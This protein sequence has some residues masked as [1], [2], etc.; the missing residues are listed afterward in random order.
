MEKTLT[1]A[2]PT[3]NR[4]KY[5]KRALQSISEQYDD[6]LEII[7][8]DNASQDETEE[9]VNEMRKCIPIKYIK[10]EEN[11]GYDMNFLQCFRAASGKYTVLLGDD[12]VIID[13]KMNVIL[14]FL[15]SNDDLSL[16]FLNH[17][18]FIGDYDKT[19]PGRLSFD[20]IPNKSGLSKTEFFDY[21][22]GEIIFISSV[23][24]STKRV[25]KVKNAEKYSWTF[26]MHSCL[27]FESTKNDNYN[28]GIV[29]TPCIAKDHTGDEHNNVNKPEI[30]F[31]SYC[32]GEK[33]LFFD[34]A[35]SC[36][37]DEKQM[38][39]I[40]YPDA[41]KFGKYILKLNAEDYPKWKVYFWKDAYPA[42]K[43]FPRTWIRIIPIVLMPRLLAKFILHTIRPVYSK[44]KLYLRKE[45]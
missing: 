9:V 5:L 28:L 30:F 7:V 25:A 13:G 37:Y 4:A 36:G 27:A 34:L 42:I 12:D 41:L 8:S 19:N 6:R 43:E 44:F 24:L 16:V 40:Y 29:G 35:P 10:N 3:F 15:D 21:V 22:K 39:K 26:F 17:T 14:N 38:R 31:A 23:V 45:N 18:L 32:R 2:I 20:E 11:I 1:I 33:Y